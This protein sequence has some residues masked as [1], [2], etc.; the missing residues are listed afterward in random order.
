[1]GGCKQYFEEL[2]SFKIERKQTGDV[3]VVDQEAAKIQ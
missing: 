1:M 3:T 2:R